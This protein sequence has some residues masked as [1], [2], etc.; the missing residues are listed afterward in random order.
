MGPHY[1]IIGRRWPARV[2]GSGKVT[3]VTQ[4]ADDLFLP[5][6]VYGKLLRS[7]HPHAN[8]VR[9][10]TSKAEALPGVL[11][12]ITGADLPQ[13][14]SIM[15]VNQDERALQPDKVRFVGDPVAAVAA[16]HEETAEAALHH[17]E[18]EY[19]PL[20]TIMSIDEALQYPD[21]RIH[22]Y[23]RVGNVHRVAAL[24]FGDV[25][26]GFAAADYIREDTFFFEGN[27][28]LPME[29]HAAVAHYTPDG[30]V[31]LWSSTQ[32]PH[33]VHRALASVLGLPACRIR[34]IAAPVGGGFGGKS[35]PFSHEFCAVKLSMLS[36]RPVKICLTREE[37]FYA[38]RGRHP[39][40]M[41]IRTGVQRDGAITAM[42]FKT[43]IDGGAYS[44]YGVATTYYTGALQTVTYQ[45]PTYRFEGLRVFTNKP[46]CG[47][48]RGHG[49]PQPRYA[50]EV[51]LDKIAQDL[52]LD[53]VQ[54]RRPHLV[55]PFSKT[56]NHLRITSCGLKECIDAVVQRSA[57]LDKYGKLS[58][59]TGVGFACSAYLSGAGL[60]I[61]WNDMPHSGVTIQID[62]S[63]GVAV[64]CGA[65]DI[66]Q[67]SDSVL[68]F[69]VAEE[70][71]LHPSDVHLHTADTAFTPVDLGSYSSRVT[72]MVGNAAIEAAR[73]LRAQLFQV[74]AA[75]LEVSADS[76]AAA[77]GRIFVVDDPDTCMLFA[78]A[79]QRT[80][81]RFG[82][83]SASGSYT[84]PVLS[85]TFKGQGVGPSPAYSYTAAVAEVDVDPETGWITVS[86]VWIGHDIGK[87]INPY[88]VEGQIEG[89][90]YMALGEVL[91]EE[92]SFRK[93]IH[94]IPSLLEYKSPTFLEMPEVA[95]VLIE[96]LDPE[97][98]YGAKEAG[99]GPLLPVIPAV[100]NA[101]YDAI[102]V[103]IDTIPITP[104]KILKALKLRAQDQGPHMHPRGIPAFDFPPPRHVE[105][106]EEWLAILPDPLSRRP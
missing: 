60:P 44:S 34:V 91:M 84:P 20:R 38:H 69:T 89:S 3:G 78:E 6:M 29:Q 19:E 92:Q 79:A 52:G 104:D 45:I 103:W 23:N 7:P 14:F 5:R 82:T 8:I 66:G 48:K 77:N 97:G 31:T 36:G 75:A 87:A 76:L 50:M 54:I 62:R 41:W 81:A 32:T 88:L 53:P 24:E 90:V 17:I 13:P 86:K 37:V 99:Q 56:V 85:G 63:G 27:T 39:V 83:L 59:G 94:K 12:V 30:N 74:V 47:P 64:F 33:Y 21:D 46:P 70:L 58:F 35:D 22:D 40:L 71:G 98:P 26:A 73:K 51:H 43:F 9:I 101:V 72:F 106:P 105:V 1:N 49:T 15:P 10:D 67:G 61:Y 4:Y 80:E 68:V 93:G 57:F 11:A 2:D 18:V 65:I 102:G 55:K 28:H 96:T 42:H 16:L 95:T 25:E 100:T